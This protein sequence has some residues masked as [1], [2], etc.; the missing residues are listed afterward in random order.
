MII[1]PTNIRPILDQCKTPFRPV[2]W[3]SVTLQLNN[4]AQLG[5]CKT[6]VLPNEAIDDNYFL[7]LEYRK[8]IGI[9]S[10]TFLKKVSKIGAG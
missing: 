6:F 10:D 9:V 7:Q 8:S 5:T 3:M 1:G 2:V 4:S